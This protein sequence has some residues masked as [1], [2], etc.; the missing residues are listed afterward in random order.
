MT[1]QFHLFE[2]FIDFDFCLLCWKACTFCFFLA[3]FSA[4]I[5]VQK[6][7]IILQ[8]MVTI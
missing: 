8:A 2:F 6:K 1:P 5:Q 4:Y 7:D 3:I